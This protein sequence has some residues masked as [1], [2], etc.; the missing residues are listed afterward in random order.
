MVKAVTATRPLT[1]IVAATVL[2]MGVPARAD[3]VVHTAIPD[4]VIDSSN[5][6][7]CAS[8]SGCTLAIRSWTSPNWGCYEETTAGITWSFT[9]CET[10]VS[11]GI[12][13]TRVPNGPCA[14]TMIRGLRVMFV[15]GL[16]QA[17]GGTWFQDA[18]FVPTEN[19]AVGTTR[20]RV[21]MHGSGPFQNQSV[22]AGSL[23]G[24]FDLTFPAPGLLRDCK[25]AGAGKLIPTVSSDS[26]QGRFDGSVLHIEADS[27]Q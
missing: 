13:T 6:V 24:E 7:A 19:S 18:T 23:A 12:S 4:W 25:A 16:E 9:M 17:I 14:L 8:G 2:L 11:G 15:S 21:V 26:Q 20:Y 22:G 5:K 1:A 3:V 10:Y 27:V